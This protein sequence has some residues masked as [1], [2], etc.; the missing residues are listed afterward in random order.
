MQKPK[1]LVIGSKGHSRAECFDW[2][3]PFPN[4]EEHDSIIVNMQSLNQKT[5]DKIQNK[6]KEMQESIITIITTGRE[7]F[8]VI[9][10]LMYPSPPPRRPGEVFSKGISPGY[11]FPTNYDWLPAGIHFDSRKMGSYISVF[12]DRFKSYFELV[13]RWGFEISFGSGTAPE[14]GY[15]FLNL[16]SSIAVNKSQKV[17]AGSLHRIEDRKKALEGEKV[18]VVHLLPPPKE[19]DVF[20]G[21][22]RLIDLV[23]G[24]ESKIIAPWRQQIE[25]PNERALKEK[26]DKKVDDIKKIQEEISQLQRQIKSWDS[27]RDLMAETGEPLENIVQKTLHDLGIETRKAEKGFPAD[28][29]NKEVAVEIT[30]IR[31]SVGADSNKVAQLGRYMQNFRKQHE[32][33]VFIANTYIDISPKERKGKMSFSPEMRKYFESL[34]V[35]FLTTQTLFDLWKDVMLGKKEQKH[36]REGILTTIGEVTV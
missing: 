18:G 15:H 1:I 14:T 10:K 26:A 34:S 17:V 12:N 31:G 33:I 3:E 24:A 27:Y 4:I 29:L 35:S 36:V 30:G 7:I 5:Y 25:V 11:I 8:C 20:Q 19:A 32:K 23:V 2:L 16:L 28:L 6:I 21:I 9:N 22:E 13:H